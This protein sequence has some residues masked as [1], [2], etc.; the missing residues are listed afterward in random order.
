MWKHIMFDATVKRR[1]IHETMKIPI[2]K[3]KD[4]FVNALKTDLYKKKIGSTLVTCRWHYLVNHNVIQICHGYVN[5]T[6]LEKKY[7]LKL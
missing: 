5:L 3:R 7:D 2:D 4:V 1:E 6:A